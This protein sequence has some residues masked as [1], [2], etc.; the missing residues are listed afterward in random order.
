MSGEVDAL[1]IFL[2]VV[3]GIMTV[4]I[5]LAVTVFAVKY[6][7]RSPDEIPKPFAG[8]LL[9]E[10]TWSVV[11]FL[12]MLV[13]CAWGAKVYFD[14]SVPPKGALEIYVVGHQWM[15]KLQHPEGQR[16]INE[17]H[18]PTGRPIKL[19]MATE[20][21]IHSFFIP[22]FRIKKDV[23]PGRYS[24]IWFQATKPGN[25]HLFC[26]EYCGNSHSAMIGWIHVMEPADYERWLS[27]PGGM[28]SMASV[29]ERLFQQM[30]CSTCHRFDVQGRCPNLTGLYGRSVEL[31]DG[32][33]VIANDSYIR[34]S[35]LNPK[36]KIVYGFDNI[37]PTFQGQISEEGVLQLIA[38]IKSLSKSDRGTNVQ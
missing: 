23:V 4:A 33:T 20:D 17:L 24:D 12:V 16:E 22:A 3:S 2:L 38:Y 36:A 30:G 35:I 19:T 10:T 29:G 1:Y 27:G 28:G 11:P 37:M 9:L 32:R 15:W 6:R 8:S 31:K 21:V 5:F 7:R 34:E 13:M 25:Y 18:V 14:N 26:A